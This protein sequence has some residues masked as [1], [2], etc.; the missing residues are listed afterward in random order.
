MGY[1]TE[2]QGELLFT[3][4][5]STE[6]LDFLG[7]FLWQDR[8]DIGL[9]GDDLYK[10]GYGSYWYHIDYEFNDDQTGIRWNGAENSYDMEHIANFLIDTMRE[11]FP[12]FGL[13]GEM[14][15]QGE[16]QQDRWILAIRDGR[17][18]QI[19]NPRQ[20]K[21]IRCPHCEEEIFIE[22]DSCD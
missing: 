21:T 17:A 9:D 19:G 1:T 13:A 8:R 20:R 6:M 5:M 14:R 10:R 3:C 15:A 18:V 16:E 11:K 7:L 22:E 2:F 12:E 4:P